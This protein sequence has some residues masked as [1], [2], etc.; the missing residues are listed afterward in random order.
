V[1]V[2]KKGTKIVFALILET[3]IGLLLKMNILCL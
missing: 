2:E 1:P 3:L